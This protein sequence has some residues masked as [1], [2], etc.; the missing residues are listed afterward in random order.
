MGELAAS[1]DPST[2]AALYAAAAQAVAAAGILPQPLSTEGTSAGAQEEA[3]D[4]QAVAAAA[5]AAAAAMVSMPMVPQAGAQGLGDDAAAAAGGGAA[6]ATPDQ[7]LGGTAADAA[8]PDYGLGSTAAAAPEHGPLTGSVLG[9]PGPCDE[10]MGP[11][12]AEGVPAEPWG[13]TEGSL[14]AS[15]SDGVQARGVGDGGI[16][17]NGGDGLVHAAGPN[18]V[19]P[20]A[21]AAAAAAAVGAQ[22]A[23]V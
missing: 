17:G 3:A 18:G 21:A 9:A 1:L 6:A 2:I 12:G 22:G 15:M 7:G 11:G 16:G 23:P 19:T 5:A 10:G 20:A 14:L 4:P 8:A 13:S